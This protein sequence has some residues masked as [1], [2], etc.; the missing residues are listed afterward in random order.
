MF[1]LYHAL[2]FIWVLPVSILGWLFMG[3]MFLLKQV[4]HVHI[5]PD[6]TFVWDLRNTG[7]FHKSMY[8]RWFGFTIGNNIVVVDLGESAA[9]GRGFLHERRHAMQNY[10]LGVL[11]FPVYI[12]E[13][14]RILAFCK[15]KHAYLDNF[16]ERDAR[17]YAGQTVDIPRSQWMDGPEDAWP[18]W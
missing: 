18:W 5:Y 17:K 11:F 9:N 15:D 3:L 14:L 13:C 10:C 2:G 12:L 4:E 1:K 7:W 8:N 6:L 16:F